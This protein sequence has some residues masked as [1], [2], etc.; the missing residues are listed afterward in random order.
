M[1]SKLYL[2]LLPLVVSA[3]KAANQ[4]AVT[5]TVTATVTSVVD[6]TSLETT[7]HTLTDT[8]IATA[9]TA[10]VTCLDS[11]YTAVTPVVTVTVVE[12]ATST[13]IVTRTAI[14]STTTTV[15]NAVT[16][17]RVASNGLGYRRYSHTYNALLANNGFTSSHFKGL[18]PVLSSGVLQ[19]LT[20]VSN[21]NNLQL[22]DGSAVFDSSQSA[23]LFQGF[24]VAQA[25]GTYNLSVADN[26]IDNWGY[27]WT[28]N[29]S[30][31]AWDDGNTAFKATRVGNGPYRGGATSVTLNAGDTIPIGWLWAN[32]GGPGG[33]VFNIR[34]PSGTTTTNGAGYFV[35]AC[36]AA[37]F[38]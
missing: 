19:T 17:T 5:S 15:T 14:E 13:N 30:F 34:N 26:G 31:S 33:S 37:V 4:D 21:G 23:I 24:F 29:D 12:T 10:T 32:G 22:P 28:G 11:A 18:T 20:F 35:K 25:S 9:S 36:S 8:V 6:V 3:S 2:A 27:L 16:A 7:T 1:P 38:P